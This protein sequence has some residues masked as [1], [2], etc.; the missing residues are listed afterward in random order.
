[1]TVLVV[2]DEEDIRTI[3]RMSLQQFGGF[4]VV[5][6]A[7][8]SEAVEAARRL[9]P[10]VVL[11]DVMMPDIDGPEVLAALR[12]DPATR[13]L[14]V[15]FL[16]AKAMPAELE[17]LRALGA[18]A[19]LTKPFDPVALPGLVRQALSGGVPEERRTRTPAGASPA[20]P[21]DT[22]SIGAEAMQKLVGLTGETGS[23]LIAELIDLFETSTPDTLRQLK[24]LVPADA[25]TGARLG[26]SLKGSAGT[27]GAIG[28]A[29]AAATI[30]QLCR[31]GRPDEIRPHID[32]IDQALGA[33]IAG[34]RAE[35]RRLLGDE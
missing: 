6:T 22:A 8:G 32:R 12:A 28:I 5:D 2:E 20:P 4:T 10:D 26:H 14:P 18:R 1:M 7:S 34:L 17:R 25:S 21:L 16:T 35:R 31:D 27:L 33:V 15:I 19:I 23:D 11:L 3:L 29:E 9:R 30:E 13:S 24:V